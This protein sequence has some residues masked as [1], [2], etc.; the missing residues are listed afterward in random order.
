[1]ASG[2][3]E[4]VAASTGG[5]DSRRSIARQDRRRA[6][7]HGLSLLLAVLLSGALLF[8]AG[9]QP[10]EQIAD[11]NTALPIIA[12]PLPPPEVREGFDAE[13]LRG[14]LEEIA[15]E[16]GGFYGVAVLEPDSGTSIS[17]RGDEAFVTASIG[18]LPPFVT[19]YRAAAR[20]ELDLEEEITLLPED[21][22]DY[23]SGELH[24]FPAGYSLTLRECAFELVNRSDNTAWVML[25]RRLGDEKISAE[26]ADMGVENTFYQNLA[27]YVA[28]P[29]DVLLMLQ[30]ISDP[31]FTSEELSAE[32]L[33]DMTDTVF[34]DRIPEKLPDDVRV[35]HKVGSYGD[36]FGDAGIVF[37][38]D[39]QGAEKR[40]Y[41]V[42]LSSG[43][44][45]YDARDAIQDMSLAVYEALA[46]DPL[47]MGAV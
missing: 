41:L 42:V 25:N 1:V 36:N 39:S 27:D 24:S 4:A 16:H 28:T 21:I 22:Q 23:G 40:Y 30:K 12:E 46:N 18:K 38:K 29:N 31:R 47:Y 15:A 45:E 35:A 9:S 17:L 2:G 14:T 7:L 11:A 37:Y 6:P 5:S 20:G 43:A 33:D 10:E 26:L 34:E 8:L 13:A 19:L 44:G 3:S 32:M